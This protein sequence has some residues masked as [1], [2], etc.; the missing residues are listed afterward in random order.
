MAGSFNAEVEE[1]RE[2]GEDEYGTSVGPGSADLGCS[3]GILET[4]RF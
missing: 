2:T 1:S 4:E 3:L